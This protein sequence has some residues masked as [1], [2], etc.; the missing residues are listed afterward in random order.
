MIRLLLILGAAGIAAGAVFLAGELFSAMDRKDRELFPRWY[1]K[2]HLDEYLDAVLAHR[3]R[4]GSGYTYD[5]FLED[6]EGT[7]EFYLNC[8]HPR[9]E[10]KELEPNSDLV[11]A[12][13]IHLRNK[14]I[15]DLEKE[16]GIDG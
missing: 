4:H 11:D 8:S 1:A 12:T 3:M 9:R 7:A 10:L 5:L 6:V 15:M 14:R 16:M 13:N 2:R